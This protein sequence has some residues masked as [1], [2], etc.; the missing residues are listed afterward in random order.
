MCSSRAL[1]ISYKCD[2]IT[3]QLTYV[4]YV[5][6]ISINSL[7][8]RYALANFSLSSS[9]EIEDS[10]PRLDEIFIILQR[11]R[12]S[13]VGRIVIYL[14]QLR[15]RTHELFFVPYKENSPVYLNRFLRWCS[16]SGLNICGC[17]FL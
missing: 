11:Q 16:V 9:F 10:T 6:K 17:A 8:K 12:I 4:M 7:S 14:F 13:I 1:P 5:F 2:P 15:P 3:F